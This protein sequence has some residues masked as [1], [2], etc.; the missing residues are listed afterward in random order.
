[1]VV[2]Q[3]IR[4]H[5]YVKAT[6]AILFFYNLYYSHHYFHSIGQYN[7]SLVEILWGLKIP[8]EQTKVTIFRTFM[9]ES[10]GSGEIHVLLERR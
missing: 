3:D 8:N 1:M 2:S 6:V 9:I 10:D 5:F 7:R 4:Q